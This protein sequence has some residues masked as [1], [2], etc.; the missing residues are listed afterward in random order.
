M[1]I[2]KTYKSIQSSFLHINNVKNTKIQ[3]KRN[4]MGHGDLSDI[5]QCVEAA[6]S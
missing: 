2:I 6:S 4:H 1:N 5:K 3:K